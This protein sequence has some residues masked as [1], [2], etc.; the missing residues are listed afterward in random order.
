MLVDRSRKLRFDRLNDL[1]DC[2]WVASHFGKLS[3]RWLGPAHDRGLS[4]AE[5]RRNRL[6]IPR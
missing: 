6:G 3:A 5:T 4:E 2:R 1:E